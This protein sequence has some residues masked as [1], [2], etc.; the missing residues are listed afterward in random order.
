MLVT[1]S[2][3]WGA[4]GL[5]HYRP[6]CSAWLLHKGIEPEGELIGLASQHFVVISIYH[7]H[8]YFNK[9]CGMAHH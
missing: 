5:E 2:S 8:I 7:C 9:P 1:K 6:I 4:F 3:H